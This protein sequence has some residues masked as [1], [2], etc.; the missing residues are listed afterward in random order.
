MLKDFFLVGKFLGGLLSF[1]KIEYFSNREKV[2]DYVSD[3]L[4]HVKK[5]IDADDMTDD[6]IDY[7]HEIVIELYHSISRSVGNLISHNDLSKIQQALA[8]ARVFYWVRMYNGKPGEEIREIINERIRRINRGEVRHHSNEYIIKRIL[9]LD[10]KN[11]SLVEQEIKSIRS[12][13]LA[14]IAQLESLHL[15]VVKSKVKNW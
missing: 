12:N 3:V 5:I 8:A 9:Y 15:S 14:D 2:N 6:S 7:S 4:V 11:P 1:F 10:E 13:C